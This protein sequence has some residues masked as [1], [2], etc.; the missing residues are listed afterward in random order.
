ML[1]K[2]IFAKFSRK[3]YVELKQI[4]CGNAREEHF[5][6]IFAKTLCLTA[7]K[8]CGNAREEQF[9]KIFAKKFRFTAKKTGKINFSFQPTRR[10]FPSTHARFGWLRGEQKRNREPG[11]D[12]E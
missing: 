10:A 8:L 1:V 2:N 6:K 11:S 4:F 5:C 3:N 12:W 9:C 7:K